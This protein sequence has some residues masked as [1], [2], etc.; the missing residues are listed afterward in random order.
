M[1]RRCDALLHDVEHLDHVVG[2][3]GL[4]IEPQAGEHFA[5]VE[6]ALGFREA[7]IF[8]ALEDEPVDLFFFDAPLPFLATADAGAGF[9]IRAALIIV[10]PPGCN[11][12]SMP[13]WVTP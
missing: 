5:F 10:V 4:G 7:L 12:H 6:A 11:L 8:A 3:H 2:K 9:V 1:F 13:A